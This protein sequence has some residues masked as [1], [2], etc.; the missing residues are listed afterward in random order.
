MDEVIKLNKM[1]NDTFE[2]F[3]LRNE[4]ER[5]VFVKYILNAISIYFLHFILEHQQ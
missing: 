2:G 1:V 4:M 5:N 3:E